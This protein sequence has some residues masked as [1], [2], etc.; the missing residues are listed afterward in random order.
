MIMTPRPRNRDNKL[1]KRRNVK[2]QNSVYKDKVKAKKT[3][4]KFERGDFEDSNE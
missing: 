4:R 2:A 1:G 3:K